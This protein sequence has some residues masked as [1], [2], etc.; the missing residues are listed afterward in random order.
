MDQFTPKFVFY[1]VEHNA[2]DDIDWLAKMFSLLLQI[3]D[4]SDE[5]V[6]VESISQRT[7]A[8]QGTAFMQDVAP[9]ILIVLF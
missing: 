3:E 7:S 9:Q 4:T 2:I 1:D 5:E 6:E 8:L